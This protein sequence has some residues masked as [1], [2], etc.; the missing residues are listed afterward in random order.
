MT[1]H[2]PARS[3]EVRRPE[4]V[5]TPWQRAQ[6]VDELLAASQGKSSRKK[7]EGPSAKA[8]EQVPCHDGASDGR[9]LFGAFGKDASRL[10]GEALV[11]GASSFIL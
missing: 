7:N 8:Q 9:A 1:L 10:L 11:C 5:L 4:G 6:R 3:R 2:I